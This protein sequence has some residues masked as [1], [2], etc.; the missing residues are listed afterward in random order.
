MANTKNIRARRGSEQFPPRSFLVESG[1]PSSCWSSLTRVLT[2]HHA[3]TRADAFPPQRFGC[4]ACHSTCALLPSPPSQQASRTLG[5]RRRCLYIRFLLRGWSVC[6]VVLDHPIGL[7][8]HACLF[9]D[10][11]CDS[12]LFLEEL[13]EFGTDLLGTFGECVVD[14]R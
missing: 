12:H 8:V 7:S 10:L 1:F 13:L 4:Y 5:K 11:V 9:L 2:K 14:R 6:A 3:E